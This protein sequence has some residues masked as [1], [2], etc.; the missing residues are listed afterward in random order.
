MVEELKTVTYVTPPK[1]ER[2]EKKIGAHAR[3]QSKSS[4]KGDCVYRG[5]MM[6]LLVLVQ[7]VHAVVK[8]RNNTM[9]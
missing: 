5:A 4:S 3:G 2:R 7:G 8:K 1:E 9:I 6:L